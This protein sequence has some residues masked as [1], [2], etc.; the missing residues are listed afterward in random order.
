MLPPKKEPKIVL[1]NIIKRASLP[2]KVSRANKD[3]EFESP[4]FIPGIVGN[5]KGS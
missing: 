3:I 4:S 1:K 5:N 2:P